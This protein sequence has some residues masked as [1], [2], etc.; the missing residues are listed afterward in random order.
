V[1]EDGQVSRQPTQAM[2]WAVLVVA[3]GIIAAMVVVVVTGQ[4]AGQTPAAGDLGSAD[5][6]TTSIEPSTPVPDPTESPEPREPAP[7][8]LAAL[9]G[10]QS[11]TPSGVAARLSAWLEDPALGHL[12]AAVLDPATDQLLI[13][14]GAEDA[15]IPASTTKLLTALATLETLGPDTRFRTSVI[16]AGDE[17]V[18]VGGGDP[19]LSQRTQVSD[20]WDYP[21]TRFDRLAKATADALIRAGTTSVRLAYADDLFSGPSVNP[22]WETGYVSSGQVAPVSALSLDGGRTRPGFAERAGN[23][24]SYAAEKFAALLGTYGVQVRGA[25]TPSPTPD[26]LVIAS[27]DSPTVAEIIGQMLARSDNDVAE[28]LAR[29]VARAEGIEPTFSGAGRAIAAVIARLGVPSPGLDLADGSGLSRQ[30]RIAP[31][32][33]AGA[34]EFAYEDADGSSRPLLTGLPV[35]GF[36]GSLGT[37]FDDAVSKV[38]AG[39]IRAKTGFLT[40][41]VALAGYVVDTDG[42]PLIFVTVADGVI[43]E[44]TLDAQLLEDQLAARLAGCGC[45]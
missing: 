36:T 29:H 4:R 8:V 39:D 11:A 32:T 2:Q 37:R 34:L 41:V 6:A 14:V 13:N 30:N 12:G 28:M 10:G 31:I 22:S 40:G 44:S 26:G 33:L 24:S 23:P 18:L 19:T 17:V 1:S 38:E 27:V 3:L 5:Q 7:A 9:D 20:T 45:S 25:S 21:F 43:P 42:R 16:S 35:A 15:R